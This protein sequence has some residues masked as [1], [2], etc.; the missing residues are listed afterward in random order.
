MDRPDTFGKW[1]AFEIDNYNL[2]MILIPPGF[3]LAHLVRSQIAVFY[4]HWSHEFDGDKQGS[5]RWD[6]FGI[7]WPISEPPIL[8]ERDRNATFIPRFSDTSSERTAT[9]IISDAC[10]DIYRGK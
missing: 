6:S 7:E 4:Y 5:Y 3:G 2:K 10:F 9:E 1:E 8:S